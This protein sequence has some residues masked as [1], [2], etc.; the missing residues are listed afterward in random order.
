MSFLGHL[1]AVIFW[2]FWQIE[3]A[4]N[5][6]IPITTEEFETIHGVID[7]TSHYRPFGD[8]D[9]DNSLGPHQA[10]RKSIRQDP[11]T[12]D[13]AE[14]LNRLFDDEVVE[15]EHDDGEAQGIGN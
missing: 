6:R 15:E 9:E 8:S 12:P 10:E 11:S 3:E 13:K 2:T 7:N 1:A 5:R 14:G 4:L